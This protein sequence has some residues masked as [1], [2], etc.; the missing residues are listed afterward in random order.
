[1]QVVAG[2]E[3]DAGWLLRSSREVKQLV[4]GLRE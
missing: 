4:S 1:M 2:L 3:K